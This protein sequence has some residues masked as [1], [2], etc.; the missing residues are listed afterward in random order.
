MDINFAAGQTFED[1]ITGSEIR[2]LA[3]ANGALL[4]R[5]T[6][7][8]GDEWDGKIA[9]LENLIAWGDAVPVAG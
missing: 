5:T 4:T 2:V 8:D 1:A 9:D 3:D 6:T 7:T